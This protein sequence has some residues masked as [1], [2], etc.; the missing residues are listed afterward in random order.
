VRGFY[1]PEA[2]EQGRHQRW[3][4]ED[5]VAR[6]EN[7][8]RPM[9]LQIEG[10]IP[11]NVL[12]QPATI[13]LSFNGVVLEQVKATEQVLQREF[14]ITPAQQGGGKWSELQ[15]STDQVFVPHQLNP[16]NEDGRR[17]GFLLTKLN[18]EKERIQ[19]K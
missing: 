11:L 9:R 19:S 17:L 4:S 7:T 16:R 12:P 10:E 8:D 1:D 5:G 15:I 6:L 14:I 13:K 2:D 3:M 18:W